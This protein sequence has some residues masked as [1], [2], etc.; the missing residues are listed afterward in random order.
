M[1]HAKRII[2]M[3]GDPILAIIPRGSDQA[4]LRDWNHYRKAFTV[5]MVVR[6]T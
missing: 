3:V 2:L 1:E 6:G 5:S 4:V